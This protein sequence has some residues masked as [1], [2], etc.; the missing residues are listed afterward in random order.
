M[1]DG[2]IFCAREF[3]IHIS[4]YGVV[5]YLNYRDPGKQ[6]VSLYLIETM[7]LIRKSFI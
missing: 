1:E 5:R 3:G 2:P 6:G 4:S 7:S